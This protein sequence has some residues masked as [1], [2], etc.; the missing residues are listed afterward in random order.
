LNIGEHPAGEWNAGLDNITDALGWMW[1]DIPV[2]TV[3]EYA[4]A[5]RVMPVGDPFPGPW[6]ND[7]TPYLREIMDNMSAMSP[8]K[9]TAVAKS[10][11][12]GLSAAAENV[13]TYWMDAYPSNILFVSATEDLLKR[14]MSTRLEYAI[15]SCGIREK[16]QFQGETQKKNRTGDKTFSKEFRGGVLDLASAQ[17]A[18]SLRAVSKRILIRDEIDGA[19]ADLK[20]GEGKWMAVSEARTSAYGKKAKILDFSTPILEEDSP[21]WE[22]YLKGDQR[23][24]GVYCIHCGGQQFLEFFPEKGGLK[25]VEKDGRIERVWYQCEHCDGE[26]YNHH[27]AELLETGEWIPT[28]TSHRADYRSYHINTLYAPAGMTSW[29]SL[30]QKYIEAQETPDGMRSFRNLY[31]GLPYKETGARPRVETVRENQMP[32]QSGSIPSDEILFLTMAGDVQRGNVDPKRGNPAR[33]ELE[34]VG[35]GAGYRTWG[36]EYK[37]FEG[38][39]DDP[40]G[41]AWEKINEYALDGG[42]MYKRSDGLELGPAI[43]LFDSGDGKYHDIVYQFASSWRNCF[44]SKG[45]G[46]LK[47]QKHEKGDEMTRDNFKR[48][49]MAKLGDVDLLEIS[50]NYYK[51]LVYRSLKIP[52]KNDDPQRPGFCA[53][54]R[55]Y[56][57]KYFDMLTAE[58]LRQDGSFHHGGRRNESLDIRVYNLAARDFFLD[59]QRDRLRDSYKAQGLT[60]EQV[61]GVTTKHVLAW[62]AQQI[63]KVA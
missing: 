13:V 40:F 20:T 44:P 63:G 6:S 28:A 46:A 54:P 38:A 58:E 21:I 59:V 49:R 5:R 9:H 57:K 36:I 3:S 8:V 22:A 7:R 4:E 25:W 43:T 12:V 45:A 17:A 60:R 41:G 24:F 39:I 26:M 56:T 10:A 62:L 14:W 34:V 52:K 50:T 1:P 61:Q 35:H 27:K 37:V 15:D 23:R 33:V 51:H 16:I 31:M 32:Y 53:F 47:K 42:F 19:P 48:Y 11:Q 29:E 18:A 55:D 2:L 30:A